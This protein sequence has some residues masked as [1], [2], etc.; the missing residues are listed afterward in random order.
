VV[1]CHWALNISNFTAAFARLALWQALPQCLL[2]RQRFADAKLA[3]KKAGVVKGQE[4]LNFRRDVI[5]ISLPTHFPASVRHHLTHN[6][7]IRLAVPQYLA[8]AND[9]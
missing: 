5:W 9:F 4:G 7:L 6:N 1:L 2:F 3:A 8:S